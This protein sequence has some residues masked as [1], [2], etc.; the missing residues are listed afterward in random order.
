GIG[1]DRPDQ[2]VT[3]L[4]AE[5]QAQHRPAL[6]A[7]GLLTAAAN[8]V[9]QIIEDAEILLPGRGREAIRTAGLRRKSCESGEQSR[10]P[11]SN[12]FLDTIRTFA[13][14]AGHAFDDR[15]AERLHRRADERLRHK[16]PPPEDQLRE[17]G[18]TMLHSKHRMRDT[19]P[20]S[21][22]PPMRAQVGPGAVS[23]VF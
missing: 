3:R 4:T 8:D 17:P 7:D 14:R 9:R 15:W 12:A 1:A 19:S 2:T 5:D 18:F 10:H 23:V 20:L 6:V 16:F 11:G 13:E 21:G 22:G